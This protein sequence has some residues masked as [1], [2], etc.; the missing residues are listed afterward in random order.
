M[1]VRKSVQKN[2]E[3]VHKDPV[4]ERISFDWYR[5]DRQRKDLKKEEENN[6]RRMCRTVL[7]TLAW[8]TPRCPWQWT[9]NKPKSFKRKRWKHSPVIWIVGGRSTW[10]ENGDPIEM[11]LSKRSHR[12]RS[13]TFNRLISTRNMYRI[14]TRFLRK[15]LNSNKVIIDHRC[16][17]WDLTS[18]K[19]N[20]CLYR[21]CWHRRNLN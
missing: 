6:R 9:R 16:R 7:K 8:V 10:M 3:I 20:H 12:R 14:E 1:N 4:I 11:N 18:T 19:N 5:F 13:I 2:E 15:K 21:R 17:R